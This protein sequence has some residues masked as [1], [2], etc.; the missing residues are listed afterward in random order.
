MKTREAGAVF[1][2]V[3][4]NPFK[5]FIG[6]SNILTLPIFIVGLITILV[7]SVSFYKSIKSKNIQ[8]YDL[9]HIFLIGNVFLY[10]LFFSLNK[11]LVER[12]VLPITP[13]LI[14][15]ATYGIYSITTFF[16]SKNKQ[17][18]IRFLLLFIF[19]IFYTI[20]L[21]TFIKQLNIGDTRLSAYN[22]TSELLGKP[23][24]RDLKILVYT[25]KGRDPFVNIKNCDVQMF[26]VYESEDTINFKPK[27]PKYYDIIITYSG[28]ENNYK[29]SYVSKKYPDYKSSWINFEKEI[30]NTDNFMVLKRFETTRLDLM[31]LSNVYVY[32]KIMNYEDF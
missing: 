1:S 14:I 5:Y 21:I 11:R 7:L 26:R 18:I 24:N 23:Q 25:N 10:M 32:Q 2:S 29:N 31:G 3:N 27:D 19:F 16:N 17:N 30:S 13:I 28:M 20:Y 15:Y 12:W 22:W 9:S 6:L 4:L 8:K